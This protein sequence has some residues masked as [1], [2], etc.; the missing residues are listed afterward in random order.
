SGDPPDEE[1]PW[2][3]HNGHPPP[4][5]KGSPGTF[6][7]QENPG[8]PPSDAIILFDGTD[9]SKWQ[10][11]DG[12]TAKWAVRDGYMEVVP[13]TG[14]VRTKDAF[15]GC[16]LHIEWCPPRKIESEGPGR[17]NRGVFLMGV[18]IQV[19]DSYTNITYADGHAGSVYGV[20]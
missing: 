9:L 17:G 16:Q 12:S 4:P 14:M 5:C 19:L 7:S 11:D 2:A 15:G 3:A 1:H 13:K 20:S 8:K 18:E 10:S 6:T